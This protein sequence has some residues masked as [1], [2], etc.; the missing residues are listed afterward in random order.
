M[1]VIKL[2]YM[3]KNV[4]DETKTWLQFAKDCAY[5]KQ[6][7]YETLYAKYDELGAKIYKL[8]NNWKTF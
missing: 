8:Y 2:N 4:C 6:E 1:S 5:L 7:E 3:I